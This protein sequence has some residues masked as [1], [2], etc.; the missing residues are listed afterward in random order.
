MAH[1][2]QQSRRDVFECPAP[3]RGGCLVKGGRSRSSSFLPTGANVAK[4]SY[5]VTVDTKKGLTRPALL[6]QH[7]ESV[8]SATEYFPRKGDMKAMT[9]RSTAVPDQTGAGRV[10]GAR[11]GSGR[12]AHPSEGA[13]HQPRR[14]YMRKGAWG[15]VA[16]VSGIECVGLVEQDTTGRFP[17]GGTV[18]RH[19]GR[20]GQNPQRQLR[21]I[22]LRAPPRVRARHRSRLRSSR[23]FP[24]PM[25]PAWSC[26]IHSLHF[27]EEA[28]AARSRRRHRRWAR[29][30]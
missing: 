19:H 24:S 3:K 25:R 5:S 13:G 16:R 12:G 20:H 27:G 1:R 15:K 9:S 2:L 17:K 28:G 14:D 7:A 8:A 26:L 21:G 23:R 4:T 10:A 11:P 6:R 22:Y 18:R 30:P 29:R